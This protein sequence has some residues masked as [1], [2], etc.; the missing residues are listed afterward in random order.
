[1]KSCSSTLLTLM[2][3]CLIHTAAMAA[4]NGFI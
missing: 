2:R 4:D 3:N 1:M